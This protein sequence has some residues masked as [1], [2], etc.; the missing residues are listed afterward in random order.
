MVETDILDA[1]LEKSTKAFDHTEAVVFTPR[2]IAYGSA[3]M[4]STSAGNVA[5]IYFV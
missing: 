1:A 2:R 4:G 3:L 5:G